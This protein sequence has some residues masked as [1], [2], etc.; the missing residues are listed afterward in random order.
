MET[1]TDEDLHLSEDKKEVFRQIVSKHFGD[2]LLDFRKH[3][4][5]PMCLSLAK[6]NVYD[7]DNLPAFN[8]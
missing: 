4:I 5:L 8:S 6:T 1:L 2:M 3:K 7:E